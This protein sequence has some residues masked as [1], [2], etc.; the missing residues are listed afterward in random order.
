MLEW[1]GS[2]PRR[3]PVV[4]R[5]RSRDVAVR[6]G[7]GAAH[8]GRTVCPS[9]PSVIHSGRDSNH[10]AQRRP[11]LMGQRRLRAIDRW[12]DHKSARILNVVV[13]PT[14]GDRRSYWL[15][16]PGR[17]GRRCSHPRDCT[18]HTA[19]GCARRSMAPQK[20]DAHQQR[21]PGSHLGSGSTRGNSR[22]SDTDAS[23][24]GGICVERGGDV[25]Q[26]CRRLIGP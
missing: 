12:R 7:I 6:S 11:T 17:S 9:C 25:L 19:R 8:L 21:R 1:T 15:S 16:S 13:R 5:L 4:S 24:R 14:P 2:T 26:P 3:S 20:G 10:C 18:F 22:S 23:H